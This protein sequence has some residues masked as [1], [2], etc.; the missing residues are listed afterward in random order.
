MGKVNIKPLGNRVVI[1]PMTAETVTPT[2]IIIPDTAQEKQAKGTIIAVGK[3]TEGNE[4]EVKVGD[5]VLF[6]K[7]AGQEVAV[8]GEELLVMREDDIIAIKD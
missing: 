8:D 5:K 2:G 4:M 1:E 3:G 6:G 7:Y